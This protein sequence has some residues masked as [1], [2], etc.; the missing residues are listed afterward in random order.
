MSITMIPSFFTSDLGTNKLRFWTRERWFN[1][2][3]ENFRG[4]KFPLKGIRKNEVHLI[5]YT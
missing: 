4:R 3:D 2:R 1:V 5:Y